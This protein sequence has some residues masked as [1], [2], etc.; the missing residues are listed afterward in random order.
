MSQIMRVEAK[1]LE[2][3]IMTPPLFWPKMVPKGSQYYFK[4]IIRPIVPNFGQIRPFLGWKKGWNQL[5]NCANISFQGLH[6]GSKWTQMAPKGPQQYCMVII[7]PTVHDFRPFRP[8]SRAKKVKSTL[9][10]GPSIKIWTVASRF[11]LL[12]AQKSSKW[13]IQPHPWNRHLAGFVMGT[14]KIAFSPI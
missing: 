1:T 5:Q 8:L 12:R 9:Q 4:F 6:M 11:D 2:T 3:K 10:T 14:K 13:T 7:C